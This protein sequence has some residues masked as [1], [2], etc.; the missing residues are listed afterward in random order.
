MIFKKIIFSLIQIDQYHIHS[1]PRLPMKT[2]SPSN[3]KY[4]QSIENNRNCQTFVYDADEISLETLLDPNFRPTTISNQRSM[5]QPQ[6][7][8]YE[9]P[10][11]PRRAL[12]T[13]APYGR[14]ERASFDPLTDLP[15]VQPFATNPTRRRFPVVNDASIIHL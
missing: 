9:A 6:Q 13:V 1:S 5:R 12:S 7:I 3:E 15:T 11:Y 14:Y 4:A 10:N 2:A 8:Y